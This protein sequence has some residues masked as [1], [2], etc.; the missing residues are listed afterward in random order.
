MC[1]HGGAGHDVGGRDEDGR[2]GDHMRGADHDLRSVDVDVVRVGGGRD[3]D[4]GSRVG[5]VGGGA[6]VGANVG[7]GAG[8]VGPGV[9]GEPGAGGQVGA[10]GA[11]VGV[12]VAPLGTG[13]VDTPAVAL[14]VTLG[15]HEG[16]AGA[17]AATVGEGRGSLQVPGLLYR[18]ARGGDDERGEEHLE[19]R[20]VG[21]A[22]TQPSKTTQN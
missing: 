17:L 18:E 8:L 3:H 6:L 16:E 5:D 1:V 12:N 13:A 2:A 9:G 21:F 11:V 14:D 19:H 22:N 15:V 10:G 20:Q 7:G 4:G